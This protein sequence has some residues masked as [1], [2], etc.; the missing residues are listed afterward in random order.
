MEVL[1]P[2]IAGGVERIVYALPHGALGSATA[3]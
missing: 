3:P 2:V 1:V